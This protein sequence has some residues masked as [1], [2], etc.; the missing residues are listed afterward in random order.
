MRYG[1]IIDQDSCIGCHAC[2]V[3]CKTEHQ[4]P[5]GVNRTWVKYIEKGAWPDTGR[6]FSVMRCNHC[7]D[8]P[9]VEICPT[10][11]LFKRDDGIVDFDTDRC[12]GC[13]SCMQA[14]PYDAL[15]IDPGEHT[16]Q[17]CNYCVHRIEVGLEPACVVVCP[18]EA[19]IAGDL[20]DATT[21]IATWV[22]GE[23]LYQRAPEQGTKPNLW[24]KGVEPESIDPLGAERPD[25]GGIWQDPPGIEQSWLSVDL[26]SVTPDT[27]QP[28]PTAPR[29]AAANGHP[30]RVV[31]ANK[32]PMPWGWRVSSY[33]L[34]KGI[35]AGIA[36]AALV[37]LLFGAGLETIW[38]R[39][40]APLVAGLLLLGTGALLVA[41][42]KRP[43]RFFYLLTKGNPGSW[44]VRGT[45][46]LG[47]YGLVLGIWFLAGVA[48]QRDVV[49][50]AIGVAAVV[51]VAVAGYTAFLFAQAEAR[52][53]WQSPLLL[54]HMLAGALV[55]GGGLSLVAS[56]VNSEISKL[57]G[58]AAAMA[59]ST[60]QPGTEG[61][62]WTMLVGAVVVALLAVIELRSSHPTRNAAEAYH[63]MTRGAF[64]TEWW[65]GLAL[66]AVVPLVLAMA[67]LGGGTVWLGALGGLAGMAGIWLMDDAFVKAG[68]SVPLS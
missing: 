66:A 5:L 44:L 1:F 46:I 25:D 15:Y 29:V 52:D 3:A 45:W 48:D 41:D 32:F 33:F 63:H 31:Y 53:L 8:A 37:A 47:A 18:T 11:A 43:D 51:A 27:Y 17:K 19:I 56:A 16:A 12:I 14:C 42:L 55:A 13:K 61:S 4:V 59:A 49:R 22:A 10:T 62:A 21:K 7:T 2:T 68:Q 58:Q 57:L 24:Y 20:D 26:T 30:A 65:S 50:V 38:M 9:C 60:L 23:T 35:A 67:V 64:A 34:T 6:F 36:I 54:W 28:E 40:A 39:W